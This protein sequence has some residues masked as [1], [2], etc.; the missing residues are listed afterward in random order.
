MPRPLRSVP[1]VSFGTAAIHPP[2][3]PLCMATDDETT[4]QRQARLEF[5]L[6]EF[7]AAQQRRRVKEGIALWNRTVA[8]AVLSEKPPAPGKLN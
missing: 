5:M 4:D 7:R 2:V 1:D 8:Q 6:E 3:H